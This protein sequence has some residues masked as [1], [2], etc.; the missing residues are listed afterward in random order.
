MGL[1]LRKRT[2]LLSNDDMDKL[3]LQIEVFKFFQRCK[4]EQVTFRLSDISTYKKFA[5]SFNE[6][7]PFYINY[8][9]KRFNI[10]LFDYVDF[11][12]AINL[13]IFFFDAGLK[14]DMYYNRGILYIIKSGNFY[15]IGVSR[16]VKMRL[17]ALQT[18]SPAKLEL[19]T[20]F[21]IPFYQEMEYFLHTK[22]SLKRKSGEWFSLS[23]ND[24]G[25][26]T[27][28][29]SPFQRNCEIKEIIKK[30]EDFE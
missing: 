29:I 4:N 5:R 27:D 16:D 8:F 13:F 20:S 14:R 24:I 10:N 23:R 6:K 15:K 3:F 9:W 12:R 17:N 11:K 18:S 30:I 26:I 21:N 28:L 25:E 7:K 22:F 1:D 2:Q 19:E